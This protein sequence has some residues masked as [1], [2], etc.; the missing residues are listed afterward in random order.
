[1]KFS[2]GYWSMKP[3]CRPF[4]AAQVHDIKIEPEA[5]T[6]YAPTK[7]IMARYEM[8][9]IPLLT[10]RISS[11]MPDVVRVQVVHHAGGLPPKPQFELEQQEG[12][13][14]VI[15]DSDNEAVLTSGN[16]SVHARK[17]EDWKVEFRAGERLLTN[18]GWRSLG[19]VDTPEGR[20]I[21]EQLGL[22]VGES[23]Y[24]LG[25]RF[26]PF[27]KNGQVVDLWNEDGGT[28]SEIAY[29]NIPFY[30]S[31]RGYGVFINHPEKISLEIASERIER[32]QFSVP[33]ESSRLFRHLWSHSQG[34]FTALHCPDRETS[35]AAS[36]VVRALVID[37]I[38]HQLRRGHCQP[39][40]RRHER[41]RHTAFG[42]SLRLLLDARV[43]LV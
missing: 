39:V 40:H 29:K 38:Y 1:M 37:L 34:C 17:G 35:L 30:L 11:P 43:Q 18:S 4:Y 42:I 15:E 22:S 41:A 3:G 12:F 26:T 21:H 10:M 7:K 25:E 27:V 19:F 14:P 20:F 32:L 31:S 23:I 28:S 6:L 33:G 9:D 13:L 36:L 2:Y 16:L 8:L 5:L 24:G